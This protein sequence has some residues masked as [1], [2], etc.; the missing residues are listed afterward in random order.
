LIKHLQN[1]FITLKFLI[2]ISIGVIVLGVSN[3]ST[4]EQQGTIQLAEAALMGLPFEE[5]SRQAQLIIVGVI[6]DEKLTEPGTVGAGLVNHTMSIEKVLKGTYNVSKVGVIT[7]SEIMEDSPQFNVGER[8]I[9]LLHQKPLFGD[10][11]S[12][13]DYTVVNQLNGK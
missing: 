7:E 4:Y 6:L 1:K 8:T 5:L 2:I 10:K 9:L 3:I 13:N 12:G 11:P